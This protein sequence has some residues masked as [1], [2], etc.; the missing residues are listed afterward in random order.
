MPRDLSCQI[1]ITTHAENKILSLSANLA[2]R[3]LEV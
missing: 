3:N 1:E 2:R